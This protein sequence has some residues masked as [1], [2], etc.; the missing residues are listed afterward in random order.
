MEKNEEILVIVERFVESIA[1]IDK[2]IASLITITMTVDG[3]FLPAKGHNKT[4]LIDGNRKRINEVQGFTPLQ[5]YVTC[6]E[7]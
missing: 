3:D 1:A 6:Y 2:D 5:Y 4:I 7:Q